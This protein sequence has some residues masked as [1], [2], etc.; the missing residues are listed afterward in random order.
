[1]ELRKTDC[2]LKHCSRQTERQ[3]QRG[4]QTDRATHKKIRALFFN[5][6]W[7]D[8]TTAFRDLSGASVQVHYLDG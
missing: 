7:A 2:R 4:G 6:A 1:M 3:T 8:K 5:L